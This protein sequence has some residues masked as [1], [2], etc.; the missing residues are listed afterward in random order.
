MKLP[1]TPSL[2]RVVVLV[3]ALLL[4]ASGCTSLGNFRLGQERI[5]QAT[6]K[7][8]IVQ[9]L[10]M[11]QPGE[12]P[13][14]DNKTTR[15]FVGT[16]YF[17]TSKSPIA[18]KTNGT[19]CVYLFDDQ[20]EEEEQVKPIHQFIWKTDDL[21]KLGQPGKLGQSYTIF[22]PYTRPGFHKAQC[23]LRVTYTPDA[24]SPVNSEMAYVALPG[25]KI[26][27]GQESQQAGSPKRR[28]GQATDAE[29]SSG[30]RP[31]SDSTEHLS[32]LPTSELARRIESIDLTAMR[33]PKDSPALSAAPLNERERA[34]IIR[35]LQQ[36]GE[37][38]AVADEVAPAS[39]RRPVR[40]EVVLA[41][42]E[43]FEEEF[44]D[45]LE[46]DELESRRVPARRGN[47]PR[48]DSS[49]QSPTR[50]PPQ[51]R[52]RDRGLRRQVL[53]AADDWSETKED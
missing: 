50:T 48:L 13:G 3:P 41:N 1:T 33:K 6:P 39:R 34:R 5:P 51:G 35:E 44:A 53:S 11:W 46:E 27:E 8:P 38:F 26:R 7:N 23:S 9:V 45:D 32:R 20:G 15:G 49:R 21:A 14:I 16:M 29:S 37:E 31:L 36:Q 22:I 52:D 10:A 42:H 17:F 4:A 24:G 2:R 25:R 28:S 12:G 30:L 43:E 18:A 19:I 47:S 40:R